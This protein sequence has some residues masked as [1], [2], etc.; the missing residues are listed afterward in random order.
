VP[1]QQRNEDEV[2]AFWEKT[3]KNGSPYMTGKVNGEA[4]VMF[5]NGKK[6][7]KAPDWRVLKARPKPDEAPQF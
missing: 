2:G 4:L 6:S 5:K 7:E 1:E 3:A